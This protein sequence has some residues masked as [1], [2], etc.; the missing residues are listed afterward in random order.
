MRI[1]SR[2]QLRI[3][4]QN[5]M[6]YRA[7][8]SMRACWKV[9]VLASLR[10]V[11]ISSHT[12]RRG[13]SKLVM[14]LT[15]SVASE[16]ARKTSKS[17]DLVV[18]TAMIVSHRAAV[19]NVSAASWSFARLEILGVCSCTCGICH[20][21]FHFSEH[22]SKCV[23]ADGRSRVSRCSAAGSSAHCCCDTRS[24][25]S[26]PSRRPVQHCCF[27]NLKAHAPAF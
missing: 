20:L 23:L 7:E 22:E 15:A 13:S 5:H 27:D 4:C 10:V 18:D 1:G 3:V 2:W 24:G 21:V 19:R 26:P 11:A 12:Y 16:P 6:Q 9:R 8:H 17:G 25:D 14:S